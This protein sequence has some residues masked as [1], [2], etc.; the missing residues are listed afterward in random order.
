MSRKKKQPKRRNFKFMFMGLALMGLF[1]GELLVYTWS[2]VQCVRAR[3]EISEQAKEQERL[4]AY[5]DNL[6]IELARLKSPRRIARIAKNQLG[7]I[8]PKPSQMILV[9]KKRWH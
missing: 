1:I 9:P 4:I 7:L 6:K 5:Q 3:Y 8:T 2:R